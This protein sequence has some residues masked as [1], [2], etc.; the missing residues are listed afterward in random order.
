MKFLS[1]DANASA[2]IIPSLYQFSL[3]QF[4]H[5]SI[6]GMIPAMQFIDQVNLFCHTNIFLIELFVD[7]K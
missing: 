3:K 4:D 2:N 5:Q 1:D 7:I 6:S